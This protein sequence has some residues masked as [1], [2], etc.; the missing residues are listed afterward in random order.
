MTPTAYRRGGAGL[1]IRYDILDTPAGM[2]LV[3]ATGKGVCAIQFGGSAKK[4]EESVRAEFPA[5]DLHRDPAFLSP[6]AGQLRAHLGGRLQKLDVPLDIQ[7]TAFQRR[8]WEYLQSIPYGSTQSYGEIARRIRQP[9]AARAVARAC[10]SNPVAVVIPCHR[11]VRG[12]GGA[13]GYRWGVDRKRK[14]LRM[15]RAAG[16]QR[17]LRSSVCP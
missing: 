16:E 10:A 6:W 13:G 15:E 5:A 8:V 12:D 17:S 2:L 14:L 1:D 3:G 9:R 4:L 7:A 11:V